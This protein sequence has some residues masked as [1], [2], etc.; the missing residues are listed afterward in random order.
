[1][2]SNEFN[3]PLGNIISILPIFLSNFFLE[4]YAIIFLDDIFTLLR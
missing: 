4:F 2:F 3:V 1:M